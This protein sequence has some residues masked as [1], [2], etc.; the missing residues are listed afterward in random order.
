MHPQGLCDVWQPFLGLW[1][2]ITPFLSLMKDGIFV[3]TVFAPLICDDRK[4][5]SV[6]AGAFLK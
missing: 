5:T 2:V 3:C 1:E 4:V 6:G